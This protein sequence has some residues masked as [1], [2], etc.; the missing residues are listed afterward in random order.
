MVAHLDD[1]AVIMCFVGGERQS[2]ENGPGSGGRAYGSLAV[3]PLP[4]LALGCAAVAAQTS[5]NGTSQRR[6]SEAK[7]ER[8]DLVTLGETLLKPIEKTQIR[9]IRRSFEPGRIDRSL[10]WCQRSIGARWIDVCTKNL[11]H[12]YGLER[13]P[14]LDPSR[15]YICVSNHRSFFD[16]YVVTAMLVRAGMPH[17]MLFPVRANFF[18]DSPLGFFVNGVMSF[19]AMYPP[20]FR[21]RNRATLN[22]AG[23]DEVVWLAKRGGA[24]IGIHP[25]GTRNKDGDPY[26]LLP[27]QS[28]VGRILRHAK[29]EVLPVFINGLLTHDLWK[30]VSSNALGTGEKI[31]AVFGHPIDFQ[32]LLEAAPSPRLY[33]RIAERCLEVISGLGQEEKQIRARLEN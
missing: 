13:L 15:S 28:G 17:R 14:S 27:A 21:E 23:L 6:T 2:H 11:R 33:K 1:F 31:I 7:T 3:A 29:V 16:L 19:F 5:Q 24:F 8:P 22:V 30:Q 26:T 4:R 18:Y 32:G 12:L 10:R 25:E 9:I 20:V